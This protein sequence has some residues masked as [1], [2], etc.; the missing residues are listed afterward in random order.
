[1]AHFIRVTDMDS[2][3]VFHLNIDHITAMGEQDD[4]WSVHQVDDSVGTP[5]EDEAHPC[6]MVSPQDGRRILDAAHRGHGAGRKI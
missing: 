4:Q 3:Q 6:V 5:D 2:G 1:M